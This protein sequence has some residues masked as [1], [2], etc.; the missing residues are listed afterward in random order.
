MSTVKVVVRSKEKVRDSTKVPVRKEEEGSQGK[1]AGRQ[2]G[3][4]GLQNGDRET[5]GAKE[6]GMLLI[7]MGFTAQS[8]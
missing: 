8:T 3:S 5:T 2:D 6:T 4:W 7:K 1:Q